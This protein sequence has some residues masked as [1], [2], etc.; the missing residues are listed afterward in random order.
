M[1]PGQERQECPHHRRMVCSLD[2]QFNQ[3]L[4]LFPVHS[5][6]LE[7]RSVCVCVGGGTQIRPLF[8][9]MLVCKGVSRV[10]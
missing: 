10:S 9:K 4:S 2:R 6:L 3:D 7:A 1:L 8:K 5:R